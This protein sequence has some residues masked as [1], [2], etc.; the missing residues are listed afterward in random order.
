MRLLFCCSRAV[1][2]SYGENARSTT[3][4]VLQEKEVHDQRRTLRSKVCSSGFIIQSSKRAVKGEFSMAG[5]SQFL[6]YVIVFT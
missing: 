3:G 5:L 1:D 6:R 2:D 4:K